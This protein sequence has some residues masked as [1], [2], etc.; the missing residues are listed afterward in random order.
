VGALPLALLLL[1]DA[2][3]P[4]PGE[5]VHAHD[6]ARL[7]PHSALVGRAVRVVFT[8]DSAMG[9]LRGGPWVEAAGPPDGAVRTVAFAPG[10]SEDGFDVAAPL[11][12]EGRLAVLRTPARVVEAG[13]DPGLRVCPPPTRGYD[14]AAS[15]GRPFFTLTL[16]LR[17]LS[18]AR[19]AFH[20]LTHL[21]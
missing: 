9:E 11:V 14:Q 7:T 19:K 15:S 1:A 18:P 2:P 6:F 4:A 8:P 13:R 3:S 12:A 20:A 5:M 17:T 21:A 10:E 16:R